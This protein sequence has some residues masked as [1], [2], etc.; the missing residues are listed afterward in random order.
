MF[1]YRW[2]RTKDIGRRRRD[3]YPKN[4]MHKKKFDNASTYGKQVSPGT[5]IMCERKQGE[6]K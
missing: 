3:K 6:K 4:K 1:F 5:F 2:G